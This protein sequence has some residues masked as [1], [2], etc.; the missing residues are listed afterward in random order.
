[1]YSYRAKI[2]FISPAGDTGGVNEYR[3]VFP[4]GIATIYST[5]AVSRLVS[6]EARKAFDMYPAA[7]EHLAAQE[8]DVVHAPGSLV[9]THVGWDKAQEMLKQLRAKIKAPI[10]T[11]LEAHFDALKALGV[12]KIVIATPYPEPRGLERKKLCESL[13]FQVLNIKNLGL[14]R[15]IDI[16]E[17]PPFASYKAAKEAFFGAPEEAD[18]IY[19][20]CPEWP[21]IDMVEQLEQDTGKPVVYPVGAEVRALLRVL[22][23]KEHVIGYGK[24][25]EML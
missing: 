25:L 18:A 8:C 17:L 10:T 12:R 7:A 3:A 5:C 4:E 11:D 19:I 6:E 1:M 9:F 14:E 2:G 23:I 22:H 13:G 24:V 20:S 16:Q 15:R 21:T